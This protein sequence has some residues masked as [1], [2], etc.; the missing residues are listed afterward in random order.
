V[1]SYDKMDIEK[2][3][4]LALAANTFLEGLSNE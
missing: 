3:A 4:R 1:K 2:R